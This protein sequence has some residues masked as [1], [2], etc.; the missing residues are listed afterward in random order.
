MPKI[1]AFPSWLLTYVLVLIGSIYFGAPSLVKA[2]ERVLS[3]FNPVHAF[4]MTNLSEMN[5]Q[6]ISM[7]IFGLPLLLGLFTAFFGPS[8]D[9]RAR[10]FRP[11]ALN[12]VY[13]V[14]L[15]LVAFLFVNSSIPA[16]FIYFRF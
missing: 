7:R 8:S 13:A 14:G 11:T 2:T 3:L 9:Q 5:V 16:P 15:T 6:G 1:P 4:G 10:E 12:C